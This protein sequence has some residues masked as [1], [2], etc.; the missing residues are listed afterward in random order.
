MNLLSCI[1]MAFVCLLNRTKVVFKQFLGRFA[2]RFSLI[3]FADLAL[4]SSVRDIIPFCYTILR[5]PP[6]TCFS[7]IDVEGKIPSC[8]SSNLSELHGGIKRL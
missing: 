4:N 7:A 3:E 6:T 1:Q 5:E 2:A 8:D